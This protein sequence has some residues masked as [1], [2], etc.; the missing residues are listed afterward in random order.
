MDKRND[1]EF[2]RQ[3]A[4]Y[5]R[6]DYRERGKIKWNGFFLSDHTL[7]MKEE[8]R[9]RL[10]HE[11]L[12]GTL[13]TAEMMAISQHAWANNRLIWLQPNVQD[14]NGNLAA[15]QTGQI[16]SFSS[17]GLVLKKTAWAWDEIRCIKEI[18]HG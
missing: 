13:T 14:Q 7:K 10:T 12:S 17:E 18:E 9:E 16:S 8:K 4:V 11:K 5:F 3:V 6:E 15:S 1:P 2:L